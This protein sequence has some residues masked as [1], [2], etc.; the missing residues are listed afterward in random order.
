MS[1]S[2]TFAADLIERQH[3]KDVDR[4]PSGPKLLTTSKSIN[5]LRLLDVA[6]QTQYSKAHTFPGP[7]PHSQPLLTLPLIPHDTLKKLFSHLTE[8]DNQSTF[9]EVRVDNRT[10]QL[11]PMLSKTAL[12]IK[13]HVESFQTTA[14]LTQLKYDIHARVS[15]NKMPNKALYQLYSS[16]TLVDKFKKVS[17]EITFTNSTY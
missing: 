14:V 3:N 17:L 15:D 13:N 11:S 9:G 16:N 7:L 12:N 10:L 8:K 6:K 5:D 4:E 2:L 1:C